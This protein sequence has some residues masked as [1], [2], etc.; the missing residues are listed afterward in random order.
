MHQ[1]TKTVSGIRHWYTTTNG[2]LWIVALMAGCWFSCSSVPQNRY[3]AV[4]YT[5]LPSED[6][7]APLPIAVRLR[8]LEISPAYDQERLVYRYSPY[9]F[10]YYDYMLWAVK[11]QKMLTDLISRHLEQEKL[12]ETIA[13]ELGDRRPDY[14]LSG[15]VDAIEELDAGAEW[16][17][18][19]AYTL[20]LTR[21]GDQ[22]V[23]W[24]RS[25]DLKKRVYNKAPVYVVKA[26]SE[27]VE[28]EL[29][30]TTK[31]LRMFFKQRA[32]PEASRQGTSTDGAGSP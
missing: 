23:V 1:R 21:F 5:V 10:M 19:L 12:F 9:E 17:A 13:R 14:E 26:L 18:H 20:H 4:A 28:E 22:R 16:S 15:T 27:L 25:A 31:Q 8:Q 7:G 29:N 6:K 24:S 11:P 30:T 2:L 3:F 32:M